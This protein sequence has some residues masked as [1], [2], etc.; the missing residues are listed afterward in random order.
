M[1]SK[2]AIKGFSCCR[3]R[4]TLQIVNS[5][6]IL[7]P[8]GQKSHSIPALEF[9]LVHFLCMEGLYWGDSHHLRNRV[10][11]TRCFGQVR[12]RSDRGNWVPGGQDGWTPATSLGER[13]TWAWTIHRRQSGDQSPGLLN[14]LLGLALPLGPWVSCCKSLDLS[15]TVSEYEISTRGP[16][17]PHLVWRVCFESG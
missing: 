9:V 1:F 13:H 2:Y 15:F 5:L 6:L 17:W 3:F 14:Q 10:R 11:E 16:P 12:W 7:P 8:N 4:L